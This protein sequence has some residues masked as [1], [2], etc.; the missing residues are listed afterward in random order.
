MKKKVI[1]GNLIAIATLSGI[2]M[3]SP[4]NQE[5][6]AMFATFFVLSMILLVRIFSLPNEE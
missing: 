4:A 5:M 2:L 3:A 6:I 1:I